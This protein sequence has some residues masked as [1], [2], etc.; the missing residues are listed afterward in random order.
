MKIAII[1]PRQY[2]EIT[3]I[4]PRHYYENHNNKS[5]AII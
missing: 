5:Q 2:Y 4:N 3:M 1:I